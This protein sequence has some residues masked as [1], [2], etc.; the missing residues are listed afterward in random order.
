MIRRTRGVVF[1]TQR[2]NQPL[3]PVARF[4]P[5]QVMSQLPTQFGRSVGSTRKK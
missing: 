1:G 4:N 5:Y 3:V 2:P